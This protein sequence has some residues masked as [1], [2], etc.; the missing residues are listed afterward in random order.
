MH[1]SLN[2]LLPLWERE[3]AVD[4]ACVLAIVVRTAGSTYRKA[5]APML[6]AQSGEYAGLLSGGCLESDLREH[7]REV[8]DSREARLVSYDMRSPDDLIFGL[9]A[10]CEGAMEILLLPL[11]A[12]NGWQPLARL[13]ANLQTHRA[14]CIAVVVRSEQAYLPVGTAVLADAAAFTPHGRL[15]A[16]TQQA[17]QLAALAAAHKTTGQK[18]I[19]DALAGVDVLLTDP[20]LPPRL[21]ILGAGPDAKPVVELAYFLGWKAT[22]VDHRPMYAQAERF[23]AAEQ[24]INE[25]PQLLS[26]RIR[27]DD[28]QACIVMSHHLSSD[29]EYL[30]AVASSHIDYVGLLG[31]PARRERLLADAGEAAANLRNRLHAPVGLDIGAATPESIALSIVTE[32]HAA[33]HGRTFMRSS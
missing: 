21:L 20:D 19:A 3:R 29:L 15:S 32:I 14:E 1:A 12:A 18:F 28:F 2:R 25:R 27:L 16:S 8:I 4:R 13:A 23:P 11:S 7:A 26:S 17:Q 31:P 9:G 10:G 22:V 6:I 5:G 30:K 24:V 33:L